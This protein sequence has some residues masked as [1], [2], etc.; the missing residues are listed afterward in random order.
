MIPPLGSAHSLQIR[1]FPRYKS[2]E[3]QPTIPVGFFMEKNML[4]GIVSLVLEALRLVMAVLLDWA[5]VHLAM[6]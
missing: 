2:H 4:E 5:L 1:P 6:N 3:P